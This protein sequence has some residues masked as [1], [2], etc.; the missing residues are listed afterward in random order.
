M[1]ICKCGREFEKSQSYV[2]HCGHCKI[3]LG[4]DPEDRFRESRRFNLGKHYPSK[5]KIPIEDI[6]SNKVKGYLPVRL[7]WRLIEEGYKEFKCER[8]GLSEW[9]GGE[10]PLELHH[11]NGDKDDNELSNLQILCPN[12]HALTPNYRWR[13]KNSRVH[14]Q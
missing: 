11:I 13:K 10:I 3:H 8:C 4:R 9:L 12:C 6:L 5:L 7:K 14:D 1:Y 2:A